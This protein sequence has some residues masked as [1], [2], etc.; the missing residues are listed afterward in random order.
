GVSVMYGHS[1]TMLPDGKGVR[2]LDSGRALSE[3]RFG[4]APPRRLTTPLTSQHYSYSAVS[5]D[6]KV[7]SAVNTDRKL[8]LVN[9]LRQE[10]D[11]E[12]ATL[13][14]YYSNTMSFSPDGRR[15]AVGL[16]NK[17]LVLYDVATGAELRRIAPE[18]ETRPGHH[19][20]APRV[21]FGHDG[22]TFLRF[23]GQITAMET[24]TGAVRFRL[25]HDGGS[26]NQLAWSP[27]SRLVGRSNSDGTVIVYDTYTG[28][29]V[30][31]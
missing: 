16:T 31:R 30:L 7:M 29:E 25:P 2:Y 9:L 24:V 12:L 11:R 28:K 23:D 5:P 15:L 3:L 26:L 13:D 4:E 17:Q 20:A 14:Q 6:G 21:D 1:L 10:K 19:Y 22:R 8:R 27:D 18:T